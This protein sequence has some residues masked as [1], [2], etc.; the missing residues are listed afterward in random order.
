MTSSEDNAS[1]GDPLVARSIVDA[2]EGSPSALGQLLDHYRGYL[3][4]LANQELDAAL[5]PKVAHSDLVQETFFQAARDFPK[6]QG[7]TEAELRAWLR[8]IL[9]HRM[10]DAARQFRQTAKRSIDKELP[11]DAPA[12]GGQPLVSCEPSPSR[13]LLSAEKQAEVLAALA[14][15]EESH[16][17][18]IELR[19]LAGMSF[20]QVGESLG[21]SAEAARKLWSRA[22]EKLAEKLEDGSI[23]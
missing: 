14:T 7:Q 16:R 13:V 17:R 18:A 23:A 8:Q 19:S 10:L 11:I 6:F 12:A 5:V 1:S 20:E 4:G 2:R 15:L 9:Q 3:L 21:R 22:I